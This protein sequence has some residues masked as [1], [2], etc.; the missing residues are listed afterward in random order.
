MRKS[1]CAI[2]FES[3]KSQFHACFHNFPSNCN[4]IDK[5]MT[6]DEGSSRSIYI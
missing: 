5:L 6:Y 3:N 4:I 1:I 2:S